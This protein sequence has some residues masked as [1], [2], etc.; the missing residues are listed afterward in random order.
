MNHKITK[1]KFITIEGVEGVGKS[2]AMQCLQQYLQAH[3]V[4]AVF[5]REPGGTEIAEAI[6]QTLLQPHS[7]IMSPDT[8]L[9][10]MFASRA[11]HLASVILP[12]LTQ[13]KV[14]ISDRFTD[15]TYAYQGG[16]R[17][18]NMDRIAELEKFVQ[19]NF[20]PNLTLL[21][22][23]PVE[24]GFERI[25]ARGIK[26]RIEQ[27]HLSFFQRVRDCYLARAKRYPERFKVIDATKPMSQVHDI[28]CEHVRE[29]LTGDSV[30]GISVA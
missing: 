3:D 12:A 24:V 19:G 23:A 8:E 11:Q 29:V 17:G 4:A 18:I 14:V 16:G 13:N 2:S 5:T 25:A 1:G 10:L 15:A 6:R 20:Q 9:L 21:L 27:E 7:E 26:D 30:N 22:D 28:I